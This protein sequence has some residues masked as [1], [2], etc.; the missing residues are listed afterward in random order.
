MKKKNPENF[1]YKKFYVKDAHIFKTTTQK[2]DQHS[3]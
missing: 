3:A 2:K 1:A